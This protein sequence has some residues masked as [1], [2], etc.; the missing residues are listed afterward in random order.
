MFLKNLDTIEPFI[1]LLSSLTIHPVNSRQDQLYSVH[2]ASSLNLFGV[3]TS[4]RMKPNLVLTSQCL[5]IE[6][7]HEP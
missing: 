5:P 2:S 3:V 6:M 7:K 1:V 4:V